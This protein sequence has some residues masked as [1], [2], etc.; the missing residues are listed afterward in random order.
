MVRNV[1]DEFY[2]PSKSG[3][4]LPGREPNRPTVY[5]SFVMTAGRFGKLMLKQMYLALREPQR[6]SN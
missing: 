6:T 5:Y 1:S 2:E 3:W 4:S